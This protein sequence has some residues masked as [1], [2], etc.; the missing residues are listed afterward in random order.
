MSQ[1]ELQQIVQR[2]AGNFVENVLDTG[3]PVADQAEDPEIQR[4]ML[5][6]VTSYCSGALDVAS[7]PLPEVS[8]LDTLVFLRLSRILME[9]HW[10][11]NVFGDSIEPL[12]QTFVTAEQKVMIFSRSLLNEKEQKTLIGLIDDWLELHPRTD[13]GWMVRFNS[14]PSVPARSGGDE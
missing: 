11:P 2:F 13:L 3:L 1:F 12:H 6:R 7:G 4:Q 9:R 14:S 10:K 5:E 8:V